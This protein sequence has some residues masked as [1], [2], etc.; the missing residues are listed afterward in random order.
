MLV[1]DAYEI[2]QQ[3]ADGS[4]PQNVKYQS[5]IIEKWAGKQIG[6]DVRNDGDLAIKRRLRC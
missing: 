1:L 6:N 4:D 5:K 2:K 3:Q